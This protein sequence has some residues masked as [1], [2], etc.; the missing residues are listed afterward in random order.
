M[1]FS[2]L[3]I[4]R[5]NQFTF[6]FSI[7]D[8]CKI[9]LVFYHQIKSFL[10]THTKKP[11]NKPTKKNPTQAASYLWQSEKRKKE[12]SLHC[13]QFHRCN[14][15]HHQGSQGKYEELG[16]CQ[17]NVS[18]SSSHC[19]LTSSSHWYRFCRPTSSNCCISSSMLPLAKTPWRRKSNSTQPHDQPPHSPCCKLHKKKKGIKNY[20]ADIVKA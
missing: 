11:P 2:P 12:N 3:Q 13:W 5:L 1:P 4:A 18:T 14:F 6:L 20:A 10:S 19:S 16:Q 7:S 17:V 8:A 9:N 15:P